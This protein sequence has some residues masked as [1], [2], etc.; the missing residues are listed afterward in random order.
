VGGGGRR[1][2][3]RAAA[4]ASGGPTVQTVNAPVAFARNGSLKPLFKVS[5]IK[6]GLAIHSVDYISVLAQQSSANT[7]NSVA[8]PID[9][10]DTTSFPYV[11]GTIGP[12]FEKY[13]LKK[14]V[15]HYVHFCPT[16]QAGSVVMWYSPDVLA[17]APTSTALAVNDSNSCE[18]AV[19]EDLQMEVDLT[20][21]SV[22]WLYVGTA[23]NNRLNSAGQAMFATDK[24]PA[25]NANVG[26]IYLET[27]WEFVNRKL[28]SQNEPVA[29]LRRICASSLEERAKRQMLHDL[30]DRIVLEGKKEKKVETEEES[31]VRRLG[32]INIQPKSTGKYSAPLSSKF[33]TGS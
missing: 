13:R 15:L 31:L 25:G 12:A 28:P 27:V 32:L 33:N 30:V 3:P 11:A 29:M 14:L 18:G 5:D 2:A 16:S 26:D 1:R 7:F 6:D 23:T 20:G 4:G 24:N 9:P 8:L 10:T 19:Y 22:D 21:L 17:T